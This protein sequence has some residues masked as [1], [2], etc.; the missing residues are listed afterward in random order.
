MSQLNLRLTDTGYWI[1]NWMGRD[2]H[3]HMSTVDDIDFV[4]MGLI[5]TPPVRIE[6]NLKG[7]ILKVTNNRTG[8]PVTE[9]CIPD[10]HFLN[11]DLN[12]GKP[13]LG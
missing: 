12:I 13:F 11:R 3:V 4:T 2:H 8:E 9:M 1:T 6:I 5:D 10:N 7:D